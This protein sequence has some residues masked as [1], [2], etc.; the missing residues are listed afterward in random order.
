M[1]K[2][3]IDFS[4]FSNAELDQQAESVFEKMTERVDLFADP[5]PALT[6]IQTG[7]AD[8]RSALVAARYNDRQS[9][10]HRDRMRAEL[11]AN[12]RRLALYVDQVADGDA[13]TILAAGYDYK[14]TGI[15]N[16]TATPNPKPVNLLAV[17]VGLGTGRVK[18]S[19]PVIKT[20]RM[21][22]FEHR[23]A[24]AEQWNDLVVSKAKLELSGLESLK[25]YEFRA[26]YIGT[27]PTVTYSDVVNGYVL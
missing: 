5:N 3:K 26:A 2:P 10:I 19:V 7:L 9:I 23:L 4:K 21:Y 8:F 25:L 24:G 6:V 17:P 20:A 12:L 18:L 15:S 13:F 16:G 27:N 11:E 14:Q 22:R 1:A